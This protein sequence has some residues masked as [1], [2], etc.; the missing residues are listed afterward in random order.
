MFLDQA[1]VQPSFVFHP[2]SFSLQHAEESAREHEKSSDET[3]GS[4][5]KAQKSKAEKKRGSI[6]DDEEFKPTTGSVLLHIQKSSRMGGVI[7]VGTS[8][9]SS[10]LNS[11]YLVTG[12][13]SVTV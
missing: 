13:W 6:E 8:P 4:T 1:S 3:S 9:G 5:S 12:S 7:S 10:F 2:L 11:T